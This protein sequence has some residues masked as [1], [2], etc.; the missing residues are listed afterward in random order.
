MLSQ[1]DCMSGNLY[2]KFDS[3]T[4]L[5]ITF[6]PSSTIFARSSPKMRFTI[7][8]GKGSIAGR[9]KADANSFVN[10]LFVIT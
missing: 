1:A 4:L 8:G 2:L 7:K 9:H 3:R 10:S 5:G 6:C